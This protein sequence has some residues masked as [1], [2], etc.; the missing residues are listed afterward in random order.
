MSYQIGMVTEGI[1]AWNPH[2][3]GETEILGHLT[4]MGVE[5]PLARGSIAYSRKMDARGCYV[6]TSHKLRTS[7]SATT[8]NKEA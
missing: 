5:E 7:S 8:S 1:C 6:S 4:D 3:I 2:P